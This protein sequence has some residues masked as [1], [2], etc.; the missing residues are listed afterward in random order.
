M[1]QLPAPLTPLDC[2]TRGLEWMPLLG[3]RLFSSQTWL[4]ANFEARCAMLKLWW[5]SWKQHPAASLPDD[6]RLLAQFAG[7]EMSPKGWIKI[8]AQAMRGWIKCSDGL[9]YHPLV[10]ELAIK[11]M[12][13]VGDKAETENAK[14]ERQKR[15]R[16]RLRTLAERL[17]EMGATPPRGASLETMERLL[18]DVEASTSPSTQASTEITEM[19]TVSVSR[20]A[21]ETGCTGEYSRGESKNPP[22]PPRGGRRAE[23]KL[24]VLND[25]ELIAFWSQF[26]EKTDGMG[27]CGPAWSAARRIANASEIMAGLAKYPFKKGFLPSASRWL[28]E[29]RWMTE[30]N[31]VA[32]INPN[33]E[34]ERATRLQ[35]WLAQLT[36]HHGDK[37]IGITI[38]GIDRTVKRLG[39][40]DFTRWLDALRNGD[41]WVIAE[42]RREVS[43]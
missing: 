28:N 26:P 24:D 11:A 36:D 42:L 35:G 29:C 1:I 39:A 14:T 34:A 20:D 2:D 19:S 25:P 41:G 3:D 16:D 18:R 5:L 12:G 17:R 27:A 40:A 30:S 8:R 13:K 43:A 37:M 23:R 7:Y 32:A 33:A 31:E 6:D 10:A 22:L 21:V 9:L 15:W 38:A 4:L